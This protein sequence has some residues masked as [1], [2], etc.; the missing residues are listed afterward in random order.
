MTKLLSFHKK[1]TRLFLIDNI[2][3]ELLFVR[4]IGNRHSEHVRESGFQ[5]L[6]KSFTKNQRVISSFC[7]CKI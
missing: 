6:N 2:I 4:I 5:L 3:G 1:I 7:F